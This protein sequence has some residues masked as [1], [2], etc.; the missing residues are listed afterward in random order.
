MFLAIAATSVQAL[1]ARAFERAEFFANCAGRMTALAVHQDGFGETGAP[2]MQ[3]LAETF[4]VLLDATLPAAYAEGVPA[5][6]PDRWRNRGWTEMAALLTQVHLS[7]DTISSDAAAEALN[8]RVTSC[9]SAL[10]PTAV[11]HRHE[12][13]HIIRTQSPMR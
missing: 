2:A 11:E 13:R 8:A 6:D 12:H 5:T 3:E 7:F 1:P 9:T 4:E 10:L